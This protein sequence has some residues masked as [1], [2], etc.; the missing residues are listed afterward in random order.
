MRAGL[1][2]HF[3]HGAPYRVECRVRM[4]DGSYRWMI[5]IGQGVRD[6]KGWVV[7][8]VGST[9]DIDPQ[10]R[11][12]EALAQAAERYNFLADAMPHIV[13]TATP[14]GKFEDV[15]AS[16]VKFTGLNS[17]E[18]RLLGDEAMRRV[19]HEDE[20]QIFID[21]W[22][23]SVKTGEPFELEYRF[24]RASDEQYRWH[25][26]LSLPRRDSE[27]RIVQWVGTC[28][29]IHEQ[30]AEQEKP[31]PRERALPAGKPRGR[32]GAGQ[33]RGALCAAHREQPA[34]VLRHQPADR[35]RLFLPALE[36]DARLRAAGIAGSICRLDGAVASGRSRQIQPRIPAPAGR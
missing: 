29:D 34:G 28:T 8:M 9:S 19:V 27:G 11:A 1:R 4:A 22:Q 25:L 30:K 14:D 13:W 31:P 6:E 24:R 10:R 32:G 3:K 17:S 5:N 21:R 33:E 2:E 15:N 23:I 26:G 36:T 35:R 7:R 12:A 16:W 20:A 18:I